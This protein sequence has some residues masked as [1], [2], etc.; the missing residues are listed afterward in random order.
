MNLKNTTW[1]IIVKALEAEIIDLQEINESLQSSL[2]QCRSERLGLRQE[3]DRL[4]E[5]YEPV[6]KI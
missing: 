6:T 4:K 5:L 3:H 1:E 2:E